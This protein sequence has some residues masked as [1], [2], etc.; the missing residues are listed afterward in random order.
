MAPERYP[1]V[2]KKTD[3]SVYTRNDDAAYTMA[4]TCTCCN[5]PAIAYGDDMKGL[6]VGVCSKGTQSTV[7]AS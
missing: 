6:F 1:T 2:G 7:M 5:L 4:Y 3:F